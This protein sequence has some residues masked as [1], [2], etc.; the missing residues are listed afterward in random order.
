MLRMIIYNENCMFYPFSRRNK[1]LRQECSEW[2]LAHRHLLMGF[3]LRQVDSMT[4]AEYLLSEVIGKVT[5]SFLKGKLPQHEWLPYTY[6]AIRNAA[7]RQKQKNIHRLEAERRYGETEMVES[8]V[9]PPTDA[10]AQH[11]QLRQMLE[12]L[13][14][15]N[16]RI[17]FMKIWDELPVTEIARRLNMPESTV[18]ARLRAALEQLRNN[19]S[20]EDV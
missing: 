19:L 13:A 8:F 10:N 9:F 2:F 11:R 3:T 18:R 6:T 14:P 1:Q 4:D 15:L 16:R 5:N 17:V 7:I 12:A 20:R